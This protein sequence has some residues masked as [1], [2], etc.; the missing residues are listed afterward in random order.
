[1]VTLCEK[2]IRIF[3]QLQFPQ[4]SVNFAG[5]LTPGFQLPHA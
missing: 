1:M 4:Y 3:R 5:P 2:Q